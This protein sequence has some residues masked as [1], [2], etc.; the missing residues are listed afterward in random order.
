MTGAGV[1]EGA[2]LCMAVRF[3]VEPPL[4][5]CAHCHCEYCRRAHGAAFVTWVGV[6]RERFRLTAGADLLR[7]FGVSEEARRQFCH[8]CGSMLFF[9]GDRWP[10]EVHVARAH[11]LTPVPLLPQGHAYFEQAVDWRHTE[12]PAAAAAAPAAGGAP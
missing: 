11:F 6:A 12:E 5:W 10:G 2:C 8:R 3:E 4:L 7:T 1:L 9:T